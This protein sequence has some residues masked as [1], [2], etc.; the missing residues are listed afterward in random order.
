MAKLLW[1][2]SEERI[3]KT[4][5]YRFMGVVN[6]KYDKDFK[7]YAPLYQWSIDN[8]PDFWETMWEFAEIRAFFE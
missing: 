4:N 1:Q 2:P 5:M 8:I 3:R 7:E 6:E